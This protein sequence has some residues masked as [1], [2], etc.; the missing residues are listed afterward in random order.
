M[1]DR[2]SMKA[3]PIFRG[4]RCLD[5]SR[6]FLASI[7]ISAVPLVASSSAE[8]AD[9]ANP[10]SKP[11]KDENAKAGQ[12]SK[13]VK[14]SSRASGKDSSPVQDE[15]NKAN[16]R[17]QDMPEDA[18]PIDD[19]GDQA[20]ENSSPVED[21]SKAAGN[22]SRKIRDSNSGKAS[23]DAKRTADSSRKAGPEAATVNDGNT[24]KANPAARAT[25]SA[26][27]AKQADP[28][29]AVQEVPTAFESETAVRE[30]VAEAEAAV[31][32]SKLQIARP[33]DARGIISGILAE[34]SPVAR[35][36]EARGDVLADAA[37]S[38]VAEVP[39]SRRAEGRDYLRDRLRGQL[40]ATREAPRFFRYRGEDY[41]QALVP[42]DDAL[43]FFGS[44]RRYVHFHSK[45]SIPAVLLAN[46]SLGNVNV[47]T[48]TEANRV[49][50]PSESQLAVLPEEYR[51]AEAWVIS[52][53]VSK[54]NMISSEDIVFRQGSTQFADIH[55]YDMIQML[56]EAIKDPALAGQRI[57]IEGHTS[58]EGAFEE[59]QSLSQHRAEAIARE[60]IRN[61][62]S[63]EKVIPVGFGES[64]ARHAANAPEEMRSRD[65]R[66]ILFTLE[67]EPGG[68]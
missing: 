51:A 34:D 39:D 50:A 53:P 40:A 35:A 48:A 14:D 38:A 66:V 1:S 7:L 5:V 13:P 42:A 45:T 25:S 63:P 4:Q 43:P 60:L 68:D 47:L 46:A 61:G 22:D 15:G 55:A 29:P 11:V 3:K 59:N 24:D 10:A 21:S 8:P 17:S 12:N 49:F 18:R 54:E 41:Q 52:Y 27:R 23:P 31:R 36:E 28:P 33:E 57:V 20:N 32:Q 56:A 26:D 30:A 2:V 16:E 9:P 67:D 58:A 62:V 44:G 6:T 64:E 65:R 19:D 37:A